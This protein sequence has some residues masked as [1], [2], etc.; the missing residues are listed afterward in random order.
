MNNRPCNRSGVKQARYDW[1]SKHTEPFQKFGGGVEIT[2]MEKLLPRTR[3]W[4][5]KHSSAA[6]FRAIRTKYET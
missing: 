1:K 4:F 6:E 3:E 2:Y 5:L